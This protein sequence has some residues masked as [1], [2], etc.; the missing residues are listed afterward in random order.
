MKEFYIIMSSYSGAIVI[1]QQNDVKK[2][3]IK[4]RVFCVFK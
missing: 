4:V 2:I 1:S 3:H